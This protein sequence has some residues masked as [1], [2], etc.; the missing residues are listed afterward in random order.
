[1]I[2]KLLI[3]LV[4]QPYWRLT[5]SQTLG[6]QGIIVDERERILLVRHSYVR[7]WHLPGGG[8]QRDECLE[9]ALLREL[10]EEAGLIPDEKPAW[11]GIFSNFERSPGDHIAVYIIRKWHRYFRPTESL[12]IIER[13][14]F[15][16]ST[17]PDGIIDGARRR[18]EEAFH[19]RPVSNE[20]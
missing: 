18:L 9:A 8:V 13:K 11:L 20:W 2:D 1:M 15:D 5:R 19:G 17:L 12:E 3:K 10:R 4:L 7:G 6:V 16:L 14:F